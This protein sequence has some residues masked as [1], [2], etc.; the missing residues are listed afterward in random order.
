MPRW[1]SIALLGLLFAA[2]APSVAVAAKPCGKRAGETVASNKHVRVFRPDA[3]FT[4]FVACHRKT[5]RVFV[6]G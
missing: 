1:L 5:R 2:L 3:R 4:R 6:L